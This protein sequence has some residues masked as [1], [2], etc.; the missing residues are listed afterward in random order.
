MD[1]QGFTRL[2]VL[3][4][5]LALGVVVLGAYARLSQAAAPCA[6]GADCYGR[7]AVSAAGQGAG[8]SA[9]APARP[10]ARA[11]AWAEAAHRI[12]TAVLGLV[13]AALALLAWRRRLRPGQQVALPLLLLALVVLQTLLGTWAATLLLRE[14]IVVAAQQLAGVT[15]AALAWWLALR[16]GGLFTG[17]ARPLL[18]V[19]SGRFA[20]WVALGFVVLYLQIVLGGWVSSN[21][22]ALACADFPLC[23]GELLP[24]LDLAGALRPWHG[25]GGE[26]EAAVPATEARITVHFL[27]RLGALVTLVYLGTLALSL[28]HGPHDRRLALAGGALALALLVQLALGI[29]NVMLGLPLAV[30]VAHAGMA[31]LLLLTLVTVYHVARPARTAI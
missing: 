7:P 18:G 15:V 28:L 9:P 26:H 31:V 6:G 22:A 8:A 17:Y 14:P 3:A 25:T 23:R 12:A 5:V 10:G 21:F 4:T 1:V 19:G 11:A 2:C 24:S 13:V 16:H 30:A 29:G 20:P 27:H